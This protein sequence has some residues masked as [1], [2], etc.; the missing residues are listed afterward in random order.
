[1]VVCKAKD[2]QKTQKIFYNQVYSYRTIGV[3]LASVPFHETLSRHALRGAMRLVDADGVVGAAADIL[4]EHH[5]LLL[6]HLECCLR[7]L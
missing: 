1:M 7:H 6:V 5:L 4:L 2:N 3:V